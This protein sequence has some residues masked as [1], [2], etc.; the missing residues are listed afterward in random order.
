MRERL[1]VKLALLFVATFLIV[2]ILLAAWTMLQTISDRRQ[3]AANSDVAAPVLVI[4]PKIQSDLAKAL[5]FEGLPTAGDVLNPFIDRAGLSGTVTA[6]NVRPPAQTASTTV[7]AA[8]GGS[9]SS[10]GGPATS[11][12][13]ISQTGASIVSTY[14]WKDKHDD[15]LAR[16]RRGESVEPESEVLG[17]EDLVPVGFASGGDRGSEVML[18]SLSICQTFSFPAGTRFAD[19]FLNGFDEREVVFTFQNGL[20]RKSYTNTEPCQP[21]RDSRFAN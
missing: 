2:F 3:A 16:Q 11:H 21:N 15:W 18:F 7:S 1:S 6:T 4:D 9:N 14:S 10:G 8:Q 5:A 13:T 19:G 12:A 20:R 17:V